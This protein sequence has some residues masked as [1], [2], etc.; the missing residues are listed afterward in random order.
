MRS[1]I[2]GRVAP[3]GAL[4]ASRVEGVIWRGV[5]GVP[6]GGERGGE[7]WISHVYYHSPINDTLRYI[8]SI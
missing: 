2:H 6:W 3:G 7:G 8:K 5:G 1:G 4:P